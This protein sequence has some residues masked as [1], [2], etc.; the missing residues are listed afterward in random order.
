MLASLLK[1]IALAAGATATVLAVAEVGARLFAPHWAP[2]HAE[3]N[4]W[5]YDQLL[6]WAQRPG[7]RGTLRHSDFAVDVEISS[8]GFRDREYS[9]ERVVGRKRM[10]VLGDSFAW[11]FGVER[12]EVLW[13]I[14]EERHPDWEIIN[15]A[16]SGYGTDQQFL[17]LEHRGLRFEP[18]VVLLF[19]H[20]NDVDDNNAGSRYGYPKPR[21]VPT[22]TGIELRNV[23]VPRLSGPWRLRRFLLQNSY[24][25]YRLRLA[26]RLLETGAA[27]V[28]RRAGFAPAA[29]A[30][31]PAKSRPDFGVTRELLRRL[32]ARIA[33]RGAR[34][35]VVSTPSP[36]W[37]REALARTFE[38]LDVPY[39]ALDEALRGRSRSEYKF[40]N[41]PHWNALGQRIAA[42]AVEEFL[43]ELGVF[44]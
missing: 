39:L 29:A 31:S 25:Y 19:F 13:E 8:Q 9:V 42:E 27:P 11:G 43:I 2:Q 23:P 30:A 28:P 33:A 41:D 22:E 1:R 4:F 20:P 44:A 37:L 40:A 24:L 7:Q 17:F 3:R 14:L 6:G 36:P 15:T 12:H 5:T 35:V 21:F 10:L 32:H 18:D 34:L 26:R 38:P 16:V